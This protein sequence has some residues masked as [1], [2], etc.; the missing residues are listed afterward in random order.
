LALNPGDKLGLYEITSLLGVGG[1]GEVYRAA[2]PK[3]KR[4]VAIKILPDEFSDEPNWISRFQREAEMLASLNHHNIASI[5]DLHQ[6]GKTRFLILELVEGETLADILR[7]RGALPLEDPVEIGKQICDALE[8]AHQ[9][10][11]IHRDLKPANIKVDQNGKVKVLDFGLAKAFAPHLLKESLSNSPTLSMAA[12]NA[13]VI[14]G[15][16][17]YMS[18]EQARGRNMDRRTDVWS[19]GCVLYEMLTGRQAFR[20]EDV[21][22]IL[23]SVVK[24]EPDWQALPSATPASIRT[25]L[26]RC[27]QK[28]ITKRTRDAGDIAI[29]LEHALSAPATPP[30]APSAKRAVLSTRSLS[31]AL[32][33][34]LIGGLVSGIAVWRM[35]S[36]VPQPAMNR[37]AI[38]LPLNQRLSALNMTSIAFAP[39]GKASCVC[40]TQ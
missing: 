7:R 19:L 21:T 12:T 31:M 13:G 26:S 10:G 6:I 2:D 28:D 1:I 25:L 38:T 11:V 22:E 37:L 35:K 29:E 4:D 30:E 9:K 27:L 3:L 16:A 40:R 5:Y 8:A 24:A 32:A 39:D 36:P 34:L 14:L 23:A 18:P 33:G 20:G 17:S 15:T